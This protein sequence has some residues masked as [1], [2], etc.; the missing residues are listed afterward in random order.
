MSHQIG[1]TELLHELNIMTTAFAAAAERI[2]MLLRIIDGQVN[3]SMLIG[4]LQRLYC[5]LHYYAAGRTLL[6]HFIRHIIGVK[7]YFQ[8][9]IASLVLGPAQAFCQRERS[10][11]PQNLKHLLCR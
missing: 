10:R 7:T 1:P 8:R 9:I 4:Q 3:Q 11:I 6:D 2:H 5:L